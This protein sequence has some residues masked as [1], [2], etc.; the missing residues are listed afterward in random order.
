MGNYTHNPFMT[1]S[2]NLSPLLGAENNWGKREKVWNKGERRRRDLRW[3]REKERIER[4]GLGDD[5]EKFLPKKD[6][7]EK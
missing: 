7:G 2:T 4:L 6:D 3:R 1:Q 5:G